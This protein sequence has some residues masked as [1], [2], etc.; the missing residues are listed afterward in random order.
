MHVVAV[1]VYLP[2]SSLPHKTSFAPAYGLSLPLDSYSVDG[3][4]ITVACSSGATFVGWLALT[5]LELAKE[6]P[7]KKGN[8][9]FDRTV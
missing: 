2:D 3:P 9:A 4:Q 5:T 6:S 7:A 8:L 1:L